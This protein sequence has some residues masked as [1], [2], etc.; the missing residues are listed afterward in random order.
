[1]HIS[2]LL[3]TSPTPPLI[4]KDILAKCIEA[5]FDCTQSCSACADACLGEQD[6]TLLRCI[7]LN[8][9]CADVCLATGRMVSRQQY[10]EMRLLRGQLEACLIAC[11]VCGDECAKHAKQHEHCRLCAEACR[12]CAKACEYA[13]SAFGSMPSQTVKH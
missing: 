6:A 1:M 12:A 13:I 4:P 9:D 11:Q 8:E 10:P 3:D 2:K 5:C 7:R